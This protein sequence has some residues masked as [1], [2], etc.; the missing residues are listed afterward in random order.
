M[1]SRLFATEECPAMEKL[2]VGV[3]GSD[4]SWAAFDQAVALAGRDGGAVTAVHVEHLSAWSTFGIGATL[5]DV[6]E[7]DERIRTELAAEARRRGDAL[8]VAVEVATIKGR[9]AEE[10]V[11][12]AE[13]SGA[14]LI[15][16]GHRG[17]GGATTWLGSVTQEVVHRAP[18]SVLVVR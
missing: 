4:E 7:E 13:E 6:Y 18:C 2:V 3:D 11:R 5:G 14:D 16:V 8:G 15:V 10:L 9:P 17:H 12:V 1:I